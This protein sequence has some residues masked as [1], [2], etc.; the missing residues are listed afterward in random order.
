MLLLLPFE[1]C[2][3]ALFACPVNAKENRSFFLSSGRT[4]SLK[5]PW[6]LRLFDGLEDLVEAHGSRLWSAN[7]LVPCADHQ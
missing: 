5:Y 7:P 3:R 2:P 4:L 1:R 6:L